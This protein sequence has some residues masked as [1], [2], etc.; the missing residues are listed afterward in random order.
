MLAGTEQDIR[1]FSAECDAAANAQP[2]V[3]GDGTPVLELERMQLTWAPPQKCEHC[4]LWLLPEP[5]ADY[6][7]TTPETLQADHN[8]S[9]AEPEQ[10]P[11][12][13]SELELRVMH[14]E[15]SLG[16][17]VSENDSLIARLARLETLL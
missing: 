3:R 6:G 1:S 13:I 15:Q 11:A 4:D 17:E 2:Q 7:L 14:L 5:P 9:L 12:R 8:C 10:Q 16:L